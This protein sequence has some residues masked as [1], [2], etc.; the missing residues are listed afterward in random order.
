MITL[1]KDCAAAIEYAQK[2]FD[3]ANIEPW[4]VDLISYVVTN[5]FVREHAQMQL[6]H[7]EE[8]VSSAEDRCRRLAHTCI[9]SLGCIG[10]AILN[11]IDTT[12]VAS[13]VKHWREVFQTQLD[14]TLFGKLQAQAISSTPEDICAAVKARDWTALETA[15]V[16]NYPEEKCKQDASDFRASGFTTRNKGNYN[17]LGTIKDDNGCAPTK[18]RRSSTYIKRKASE[19]CGLEDCTTISKKRKTAR[20]HNKEHSEKSYTK[21][22]KK[23][24]IHEDCCFPTP[25]TP[26]N[27]S[28]SPNKA[29]LPK[30]RTSKNTIVKREKWS[31]RNRSSAD[32][33]KENEPVQ[34]GVCRVIKKKTPIEDDED[35]SDSDYDSMHDWL[36]DD[37]KQTTKKKGLVARRE[38]NKWFTSR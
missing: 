13:Q 2:C 8:T 25:Q 20:S 24:E 12:V 1:F 21:I 28:R 11:R 23:V 29:T 6:D 26:H 34:K 33:E 22:T 7:G 4:R 18:Q 35:E 17:A 38:L 14:R 15:L 3:Q 19:D 27:L 9:F 30:V 32:S 36:V 5:L 16:K 10:H 31:K 37:C